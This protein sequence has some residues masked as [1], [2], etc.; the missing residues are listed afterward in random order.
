MRALMG[1]GG[2]IPYVEPYQFLQVTDLSAGTILKVTIVTD[3]VR[4]VA[5]S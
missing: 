1:K 3:A 4:A 5:A 2:V